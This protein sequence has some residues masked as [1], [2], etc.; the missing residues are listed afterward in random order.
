MAATSELYGLKIRN[1]LLEAVMAGRN[2]NP[3]ASIID[4]QS[5]KTSDTVENRGYDAGYAG[6]LIAWA[7]STC[8]WILEIVK[9]NDDMKGAVR[10][11]AR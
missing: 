6:K 8:A 3:S 9:R 7:V 11:L 2:E 10:R 5:V 1:F 4:S